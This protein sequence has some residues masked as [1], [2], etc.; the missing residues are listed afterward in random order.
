MCVCVLGQPH[1]NVKDNGP[2]RRHIVYACEQAPSSQDHC[3]NYEAVLEM[4]AQPRLAVC[5][6]TM[7]FFG[8]GFVQL[9]Y[10]RDQACPEQRPLSLHT[11]LGED[12]CVS[13][14]SQAT[15]GLCFCTPENRNTRFNEDATPALAP[16]L[17]CKALH[18][19]S[20]QP[21]SQ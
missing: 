21:F 9:H 16:C 18:V 5:A 13:V 14:A 3:V 11:A 1:T 20:V 6:Q 10:A 15:Y 4:V 19:N 17:N 8:L 2:K 12:T 7:L